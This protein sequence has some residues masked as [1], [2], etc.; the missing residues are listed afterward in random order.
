MK[1]Y[2][3]Q[4]GRTVGEA[5]A[6]D[7]SVERAWGVGGTW[8]GLP[9]KYFSMQV[10]CL[11]GRTTSSTLQLPCGVPQDWLRADWTVI[12][13]Y[14]TVGELCDLRAHMEPGLWVSN[15]YCQT[16]KKGQKR[17]LKHTTEA[18][19]CITREANTCSKGPGPTQGITMP[20]W[21]EGY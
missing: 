10:L 15:K 20:A 16:S 6:Q 8:R 12:L 9:L 14:T 1:N 5:M 19:C 2:V 21:P 13:L 4:K 3:E 7:S 17:N 11:K 18:C